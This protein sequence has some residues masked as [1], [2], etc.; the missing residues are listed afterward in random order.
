MSHESFDRN[1]KD[2][3]FYLMM[4]ILQIPTNYESRVKL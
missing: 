2:E 4:T 1:F 3:F